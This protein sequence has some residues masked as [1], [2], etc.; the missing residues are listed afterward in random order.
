MSAD[1]A[2]RYRELTIQFGL[3]TT[4]QGAALKVRTG[5]VSSE[6]AVAVFSYFARE[7]EVANFVNLMLSDSSTYRHLFLTISATHK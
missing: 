5:R 6:L 2:G 1:V 7:A 3:A 4:S